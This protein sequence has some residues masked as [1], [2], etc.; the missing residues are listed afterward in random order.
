MKRTQSA[1]RNPNS[2]IAIIGGGLLGMTLAL[3]LAQGGRSVTLYEAAEDLGGLASA[4][5]LGD[6]VWDKHYHVTLLSDLRLRALLKDLELEREMRWVETRTGFYTDGRLVSMSNTLE[7][8][9]FPPL[10]IL[11]KLRLGATIFY[12]SRVKNWQRLEAISVADWLVKLSGRRTFEKIWLPL[13]RAKLGENYRVVSAA[14][15]W[16]TMARM[17]AARRT[18]LKREMFG[19]LPGGYA[20]ILRRFEE[21]LR[22]AGVEIKTAHTVKRVEKRADETFTIEFE[23]GARAF[24]EEI[25]MTVPASIAARVCGDL[26]DEERRK[27]NAIRYQGIICASLLLKKSLADFYVTNITDDASFTAVIEMSALVDKQE[28]GGNALV[29]LPKYLDADDVAFKRADED[30][31]EEFLTALERMYPHFKRADVLAFRLSRVRQVFPLPVLNYSKNLPA[32]QTSVRGL[33]IVNSAHIVNGTLNVNETVQL[34]E[35][36]AEE[37]L[38]SSESMS[39]ATAS[40]FFAAQYPPATAGGTDNFSSGTNVNVA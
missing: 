20:R 30:I 18:G 1:I 29:Y 11:D 25:V 28:F 4:W 15:I 13:L 6:I 5:Q 35:R 17:Y 37:I 14:F 24:H 10:G 3:R 26:S 40:E 21:T 9:R 36:A 16:A 23:N 31:K 8:L 27:L 33:R 38:T 22:V 34:A 12:A 19:Y 39:P 7:F 32:M 2:A